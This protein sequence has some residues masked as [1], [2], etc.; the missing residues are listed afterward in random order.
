MHGERKT[1][2]VRPPPGPGPRPAGFGVFGPGCSLQHA[3]P[4]NSDGLSSSDSASSKTTIKRP[5]SLYAGDDRILGTQRR[6]NLPAA[7]RPPGLPFAHVLLCPS[8]HISGVM[9]E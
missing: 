5:R 1:A 9:N 6:R 7:L 3:L 4:S 2:P 8:L